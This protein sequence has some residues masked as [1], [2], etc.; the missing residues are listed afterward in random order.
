LY[1]LYW[2]IVHGFLAHSADRLDRLRF[3]GNLS[4]E[5]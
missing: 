4:Y 5:V 2:T 1:D 3:Q